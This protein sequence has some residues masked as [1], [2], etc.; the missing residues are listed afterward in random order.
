MP[1]QHRGPQQRGRRK[2]R[3]GG[4]RPQ[5]LRYKY[6]M[7]D[8][9]AEAPKSRAE[10]HRERARLLRSAA[11]RMNTAEGR[12]HLLRIAD[13]FDQLADSIDRSCLHLSS[14]GRLMAI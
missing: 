6:V 14:A 13:E 3:A 11:E 10:E 12:L 4:A 1:V 8:D 2:V 5:V 9:D 7:A